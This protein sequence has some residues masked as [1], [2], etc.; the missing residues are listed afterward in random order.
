MEVPERGPSPLCQRRAVNLGSKRDRL[1]T[2][3]P[4]GGASGGSAC[5]SLGAPPLVLLCE[6]AERVLA[7]VDRAGGGELSGGRVPLEHADASGAFG[8]RSDSFPECGAAR[9]VG[10]GGKGRVWMGWE[11]MGREG[12]TP[13]GKKRLQ[14]VTVGYTEGMTPRGKKRL[15]VVSSSYTRKA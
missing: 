6:D 10:V 12:V 2:R 3:G 8:R 11:G 13:Q 9:T 1:R 15:Q 14:V 7:L 5:S 4:S